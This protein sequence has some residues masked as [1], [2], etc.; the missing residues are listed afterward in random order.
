M[1]G[2][3][4]NGDA[5]E[6]SDQSLRA[7]SAARAADESRATSWLRFCGHDSGPETRRPIERNGAQAVKAIDAPWPERFA[8]E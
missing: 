7:I 6:V 8:P 4:S 5:S 3:I 2:S 1:V